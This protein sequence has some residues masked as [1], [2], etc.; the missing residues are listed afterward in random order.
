MH[1]GD[2]IS[3]FPKSYFL[4]F[5]KSYFLEFIKSCFLENANSYFAVYIHPPLAPSPGPHP[6]HPRGALLS[7]RHLRDGVH[8]H[9]LKARLISLRVVIQTLHHSAQ[10]T[11]IHAWIPIDV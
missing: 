3:Q 10:H 1:G 4:V 2:R 8:P 11:V 6:N 9:N 5:A 7:L